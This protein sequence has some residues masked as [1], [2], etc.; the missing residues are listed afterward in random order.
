MNLL[1]LK[2]V[3]LTNAFSSTSGSDVSVVVVE[4]SL[5]FL[6]YHNFSLLELKI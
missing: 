4:F 5:V 2:H 6:S 3:K 1:L